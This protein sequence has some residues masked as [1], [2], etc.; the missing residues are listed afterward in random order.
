ML[1]HRTLKYAFSL[2]ML[3]VLLVMSGCRSKD[4]LV[5]E[6][7][8]TVM[9]LNV[10]GLPSKILFVDVNPDGPG[11]EYMPDVS[12]YIGEQYCEFVGIQENFNYD[13]Q[14]CSRLD[15]DYLRDTWS[16]GI[17]SDNFNNDVFAPRYYCDGLSGF[18]LKSLRRGD[19]VAR[20]EWN[21]N[22]GLFDHSWDGIATKGF[23]RY[24][25]T[26]EGNSEVVVYN[27]HMDASTPED[28]AAGLDGPDRIARLN[29]WRQLR[30]H[31]LE[32]LDHRP[33][34]VLGDMN[35]YYSRDSIVSQFI[36]AI[37]S[38][39]RATV[40]DVW[41]ELVRGGIYPDLQEGIVTHDGSGGW[42][43][44]GETLD[45]ILYVN[46][47]G[48]RHIRPVAYMLDTLHYLRPDSV[49]PLGDHFPIMATF[50]FT[51]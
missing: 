25:L 37:Q 43:R 29:Q 24:E 42:R 33:V 28:E 27:M 40:G 48:G 1:D 7:E 47:I 21:D 13:A 8:F 50:R 22:C 6:E 38:T 3:L 34:V 4:F 23:R 32:H 31:I 10:D 11:A 45:K 39:G 15:V 20:V 35:S 16:G 26:L 19:M 5:P 12:L 49:T 46:P 14:L 9:S 51:D 36:D 18:W 41:V 30:D 2:P 17:L 44:N